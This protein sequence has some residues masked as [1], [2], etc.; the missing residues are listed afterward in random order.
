V[1]PRARERPHPALKRSERETNTVG[2]GS[3]RGMRMVRVLWVIAMLSGAASTS[4]DAMPSPGRPEFP[5]PPQPEPEPIPLEVGFA[6]G[7][8]AMGL[9]LLAQRERTA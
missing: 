1:A 5:D 2:S 6:V 9:L 8:M 4:A 7:M 3:L